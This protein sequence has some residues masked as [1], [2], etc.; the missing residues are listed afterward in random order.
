MISIIKNSQLGFNKKSICHNP[1][2][3]K[4]FFRSIKLTEPVNLGNFIFP[5]KPLNKI[6]VKFMK[7]VAKETVS[8]VAVGNAPKNVYP[9][10]GMAGKFSCGDFNKNC[11][12]PDGSP[13]EPFLLKHRVIM[14]NTKKTV[15]AVATSSKK[16][17][18][19]KVSK[20]KIDG[21]F[22]S[23]DAANI[24]P[25]TVTDYGYEVTLKKNQKGK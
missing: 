17:M 3:T 16:V 15:V 7:K 21:S 22:T 1:S 11:I 23:K 20:E 12:K 19:H 4:L 14:D 24:K 5:K 13:E 9:K 18:A 6:S 8:K 10:Q 25:T 2:I